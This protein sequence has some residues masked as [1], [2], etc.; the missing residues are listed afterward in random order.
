LY[1]EPQAVFEAIIVVQVLWQ[2][3]KVCAMLLQV[4]EA[5]S[6][7]A[8]EA[9]SEFEAHCFRHTARVLE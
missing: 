2:Y 4:V 7:I 3:R 5:T 1:P 6:H 9:Q 8:P